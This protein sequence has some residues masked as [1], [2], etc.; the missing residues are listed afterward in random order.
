MSY[1]TLM[2]HLELGRSNAGLLGIAGDLAQRYQA[3]IVGI[4]AC[5]PLLALSAAAGNLS[6]ESVARDQ[7]QI[8]REARDAEAEFRSLLDGRAARLDWRCVSTFGSLAD[9]IA[10]EA[11]S[12]DLILT[13]PD[14]GNSA[15]ADTRRVKVG[16]LIMQAGR[17]I[18]TVPEHIT[19][20][21]LDHVLIAWKDGREAR[22]AVSD[23]LPLLELAAKVTVAEIFHDKDAEE[24]HRHV[25]DIVGWLG[26][27][28]ISAEPL[29]RRSTGSDVRQI[30]EIAHALRA[31]AIVAGAYGHSRFR[32]WAFGGVTMDLLMNPSRLT[33]LSH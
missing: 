33:L 10:A 29:V 21:N 17:P 9:Y 32:E 26:G 18:L 30:A 13:A 15:F 19:R 12:A 3:N 7:A 11:R 24:A 4:A 14:N 6:G 2:V 8:E 23:A 28:G 20:L 31:D 1:A 25:L 22:R 5:Q 27:H 16:D